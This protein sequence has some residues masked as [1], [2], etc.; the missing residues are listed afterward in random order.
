[1]T[2]KKIK[3]RLMAIPS[4]F[5]TCLKPTN[6]LEKIVAILIDIKKTILYMFLISKTKD[7]SMEITDR[8]KNTILKQG[9]IGVFF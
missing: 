5:I 9:T 7:F 2:K 1:M 6:I 4:K 8:S 3:A